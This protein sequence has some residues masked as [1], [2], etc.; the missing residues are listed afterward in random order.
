MNE[1][2]RTRVFALTP[3]VLAAMHEEF[4][5]GR[6]AY[7]HLNPRMSYRHFARLWNGEPGSAKHCLD[8]KKRWDAYQNF[9]KRLD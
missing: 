3:D 7:R 8:I 9:R 5:F 6:K 4:R 1:P 2:R